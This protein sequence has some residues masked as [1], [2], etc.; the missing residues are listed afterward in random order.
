[1]LLM[2]T[3]LIA[4]SQTTLTKFEC[5]VDN[6]NQCYIYISEGRDGMGN[7]GS[8]FVA[9]GDYSQAKFDPKN[10]VITMENLRSLWTALKSGTGVINPDI[11][12]E[13][14]T[15][16]MIEQKQLKIATKFKAY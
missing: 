13:L 8:I 12:L 9:C 2:F 3:T 4:K 6:T 7:P 10:E 11:S 14:I 15:D 1:M 5:Y 16:V